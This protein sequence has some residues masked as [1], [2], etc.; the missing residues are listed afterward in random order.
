MLAGWIAIA[1][2]LAAPAQSRPAD[3]YHV[4]SASDRSSTS[5]ID[6]A[7]LKTNAG[8]TTEATMFSVLAEADEGTVAFRFVVEFD[9][10]G[11]KNRLL[12]GEAFDT[13]HQGGGAEDMG[14]D[15][16]SVDKGSQGET[17]LNFVCS[18]GASQADKKSLG[19][20][21]PWSEAEQ[22]LH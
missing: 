8:G 12:T 3:W 4:D 20:A 21:L 18:K 17:I 2:S 16:D 10:V 6:L 1:L 13:K 7:S 15:W 9:C 11:K 14:G 22:R 5:F 19:A